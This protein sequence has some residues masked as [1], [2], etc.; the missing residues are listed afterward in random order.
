MYTR[1]F[2]SSSRH[3]SGYL[4]TYPR[5]GSI[6]VVVYTSAPVGTCYLINSQE[7]F[8]AGSHGYD[9]FSFIGKCQIL[10]QSNCTVF[11]LLS[12]LRTG[13]CCFP[14]L[15]ASAGNSI[16]DFAHPKSGVVSDISRFL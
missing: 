16:L 11:A 12:S 2:L 3:L 14:S 10:L 7:V 1:S 6:C 9:S 5:N 4:A 13:P 8:I 15:L